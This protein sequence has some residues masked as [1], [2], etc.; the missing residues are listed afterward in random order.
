LTLALLPALPAL[1]A[2]GALAVLLAPVVLEVAP[3]LEELALLPSPYLLS[4][5]ATIGLV[6]LLEL[7]NP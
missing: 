6:V 2:L 7:F 3:E 5:N 4:S 1:T